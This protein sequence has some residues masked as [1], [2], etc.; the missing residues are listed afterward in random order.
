MVN[1]LFGENN[2]RDTENTEV[3]QR[4]IEI[5]SL[6]PGRTYVGRKDQNWYNKLCNLKN[7]SVCEKTASCESEVV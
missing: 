3:A 6:P 4:R 5:K 1:E 7:R 2:H